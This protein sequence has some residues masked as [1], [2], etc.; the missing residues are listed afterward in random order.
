MMALAT[1][2]DASGAIPASRWGHVVFR[3]HHLR[4]P[5]SMAGSLAL[6]KLGISGRV[7]PV[8]VH[9]PFPANLASA[10]QFS[11][12]GSVRDVRHA[13]Y[14]SRFDPNSPKATRFSEGSPIPERSDGYIRYRSISPT[15]YAFTL[16][17]HARGWLMLAP[18]L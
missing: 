11:G 15:S 1:T 16:K 13:P 12:R 14:L 8:S 6:G 9:Y 17:S 5:R 3:A 7:G 18:K 2:A 10:P 4:L